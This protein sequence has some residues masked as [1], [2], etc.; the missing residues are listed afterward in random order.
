M[1]LWFWGCLLGVLLFAVVGLFW[2]VVDIGFD[3]VFWLI[4]VAHSIL[5]WV[6]VCSDLWFMVGLF[7][8]ELVGLRFWD[9]FGVCLLGVG[10]V[11]ACGCLNFLCCGLI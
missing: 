2:R 11:D 8:F 3:F 7:T 1:I 4:L 10:L 5:F 6:F 9:F